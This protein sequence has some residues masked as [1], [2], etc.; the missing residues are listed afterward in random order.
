MGCY[1]P[2]LLE[3]EPL[4]IWLEFSAEESVD[5]VIAQEQLIKKSD[6]TKF[7]SKNFIRIS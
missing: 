2:T 6:L 7:V 5:Y 3:V 1:V 4:A